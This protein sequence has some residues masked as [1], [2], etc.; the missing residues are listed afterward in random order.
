M[1]NLEYILLGLCVVFA[2]LAFVM[3]CRYKD[4]TNH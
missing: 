4:L 1:S 2:T 3:F